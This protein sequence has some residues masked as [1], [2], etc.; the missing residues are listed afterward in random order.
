MSI[1]IKAQ[2][3]LMTWK[4]LVEFIHSFNV[5]DTTDLLNKN[6]SVEKIMIRG[7]RKTKASAMKFF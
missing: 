5:D 3:P 4:P 2:K 1:K 6:V 7:V